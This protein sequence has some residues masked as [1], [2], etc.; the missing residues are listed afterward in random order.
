MS[1]PT[2]RFLAE[3]DSF[4]RA[5]A[6]E[7]EEAAAVWR[8]AAGSTLAEVLKERDAL[9]IDL[10]RM[11]IARDVIATLYKEEEARAVAEKVRA[12]RNSDGLHGMIRGVRA[13]H[14]LSIALQKLDDGDIGAAK[15]LIEYARGMLAGTTPLPNPYAQTA[16]KKAHQEERARKIEGIKEIRERTAAGLKEAK[17]AW[18]AAEGDLDKAVSALGGDILTGRSTTCHWPTC[19][20]KP[21][22]GTICG[23]TFT[24]TCPRTAG[25]RADGAPVGAR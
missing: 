15:A 7:D 6:D 22:D 20:T 19:A 16:W 21:I 8:R 1:D 11:T 13:D 5:V 4:A 18:E 10:G 2:A 3:I 24:V 23:P 25:P 14:R 17:E 12:D 9:K